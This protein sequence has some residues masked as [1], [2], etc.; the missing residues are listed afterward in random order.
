MDIFILIAP[1]IALLSSMFFTSA[2]AKATKDA[3][4]KLQKGAPAAT[5]AYFAVMWFGMSVVLCAVAL[6]IFMILVAIT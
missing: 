4:R 5:D 1:A 3:I 2:A 6:F